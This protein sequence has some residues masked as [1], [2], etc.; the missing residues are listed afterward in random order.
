MSSAGVSPVSSAQDRVFLVSASAVAAASSSS[1]CFFCFSASS[2]SSFFRF[3]SSSSFLAFLVFF[4]FLAAGAH[5]SGS[6]SPSFPLSLP[7]SPSSPA[8]PLPPAAPPELSPPASPASPA[9]SLSFFFS[10]SSEAQPWFLLAFF[11][12]PLHSRKPFSIWKS[13]MLELPAARVSDLVERVAVIAIGVLSAWTNACD[14]ASF[15]EV[16]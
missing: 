1:F 8:P 3:S 16:V 14:S 4:F 11:L 12:G 2:S 6:S 5:S 10:S 13:K 9:P 15:S 7:P